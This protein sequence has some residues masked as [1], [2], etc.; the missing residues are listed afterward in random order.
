MRNRRSQNTRVLGIAPSSRGFGF[1]VMEG[2]GTLVDWGVKS[3]KG[4]K[5]ASSL[6]NLAS[7]IRHYRPDTIALEDVSAKRARRGSRVKALL[8]EIVALSAGEGIR[9]KAFSM[10]K[11]RRAAVPEGEA[12]EHALAAVLAACFPDQLGFRLPKKRRPWTSEDYRMDI[13]DAVA[14]AAHSL[15]DV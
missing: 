2:V 6:S 9:A 7:L 1:A 5:N 11:V 3:L 4:D 8:I 12:T 10:R 14:L 15:R 13:F